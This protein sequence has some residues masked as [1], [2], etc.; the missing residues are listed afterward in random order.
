ML[1]EH[2]HNTMQARIASGP[3][4][5][6]LNTSTDDM[7]TRAKHSQDSSNIRANLS[8][9]IPH[10][11]QIVRTYQQSRPLK[12]A[13]YVSSNQMDA[14]ATLDTHRVEVHRG[15]AKIASV[16][17]GVDGQGRTSHLSGLIKWLYIKKWKMTVIATSY[18][19]LK[20]IGVSLELLSHV[21]SIVP[22]IRFYQVFA[23]MKN[24]ITNAVFQF[25]VQ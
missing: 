16:E 8:V 12:R 21:S 13:L 22:V 25:G 10:G 4:K 5:N 24:G 9:T 20:L 3:M 1:Q 7:E 14:F 23:A 11:F 6:S 2:E 18:L 17:L 15:N 19:E